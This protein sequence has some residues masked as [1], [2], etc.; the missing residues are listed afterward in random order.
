[1]TLRYSKYSGN[2]TFLYI[3]IVLLHTAEPSLIVLALIIRIP[4]DNP[5]Q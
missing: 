5:G 4:Y 1:M 3:I 2:H